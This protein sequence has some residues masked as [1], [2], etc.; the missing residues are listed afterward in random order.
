MAAP[1][2]RSVRCRDAMPKDDEEV[3]WRMLPPRFFFAIIS[4]HAPRL[5]H[6]DLSGVQLKT[7]VDNVCFEHYSKMYRVL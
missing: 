4:H 6:L 5:Q 7:A 1:S 3:R 2:L